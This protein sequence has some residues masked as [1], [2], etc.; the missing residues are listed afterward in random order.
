MSTNAEKL[1]EI[2]PVVAEIFDGICQ[3][4]PSRSNRCSSYPHN[5]WGYW[6]DLDQTCTRCSH[7][8]AIKYY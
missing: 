4:L 6:T 8:I 7:N 2:R 1:V 5:L 3:F